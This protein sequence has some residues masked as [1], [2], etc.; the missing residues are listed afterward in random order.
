MN[1]LAAAMQNWNW[2]HPANYIAG[3]ALIVLLW[4]Y[5]TTFVDLADEW[6][7]NP[8]YSHGYLVPAFAAV[9]LWLRR[10]KMPKAPLEPSWWAV[11]FLA[12]GSIMRLG[13]AYFYYGWPDRMSLLF[14]I[15]GAVLAIGGWAACQW[16]WPSILFLGFM[17]PFPGFVET[18][19]IPPLRRIATLAG[20][21]VL[22]TM[23]FFAQADGNVIVLREGYLDIVD[24]CSGLSMLSVFVA[25]AVGASFVLR[26]PLWQ[27][28]VIILSSVPIA[29]IC[30]V[31]RISATG[32]LYEVLDRGLVHDWAGWLMMPLALVLLLLELKFLDLIYEIETMVPEQRSSRTAPALG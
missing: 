32:S 2:R 3:A 19:L 10:D 29:I 15:F 20:S 4:A 7:R 1:R 21:N 8:L 17:L 26:R 22:Q 13:S 27:K 18:G 28:I 5:W 24:A 31:A 14:M 25:L 30:N 11:V 9:L 12:V 6:S 16:S 23:G